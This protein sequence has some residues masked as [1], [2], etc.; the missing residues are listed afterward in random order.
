LAAGISYT[1]AISATPA[2]NGANTILTVNLS[3][4]A[5]TYTSAG[6][7]TA[8]PFRVIHLNGGADSDIEIPPPP[9][10]VPT[11]FNND[12]RSDF[13]WQNS[14]GEADIWELNGNTV[15]GGGSLG[16][17]GPSWHVIGTGDYN[18]DGFSDIRF[19]NSSGEVAIWEMTGT[20][21]VGGGS[22]GNPGPSW[23]VASDSSPWRN[24][25]VD[26]LWQSNVTATILFQNDSGEA[27]S[28]RTT[29]ARSR[30]GR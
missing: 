7:L 28:G 23:H 9:S 14:S 15:I 20:S 29:T 8:D 22:L 17:P 27:S 24:A 30:S 10:M 12:G 5:L 11:D 21:I 1:T 19:Q 4:G 25:N 26:L 3:S 2:L 16:N 18:G 13:L 6:N